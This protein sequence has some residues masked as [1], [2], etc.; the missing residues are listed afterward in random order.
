M[1]IARVEVQNAIVAAAMAGTFRP[2]TYDATTHAASFDSDDANK[3]VPSS[4]VANEL[5]AGFAEAER[6]RRTHCQDKKRW[7]FQ[8]KLEFQQ[9]VTLDEFEESLLA[10]PLTVNR[11][12]VEGLTHRIEVFFQD[13][14]YV[15][16]IQQEPSTGTKV[17]YTFEARLTPR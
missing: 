14:Q 17:T 6:N 3:V 7:I 1:K 13:V 11:D 9:E 4:A 2:V 8:L 12:V 15:H 16:P 5:S 10:T